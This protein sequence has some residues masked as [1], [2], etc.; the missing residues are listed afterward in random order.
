MGPLSGTTHLPSPPKNL[1]FRVHNARSIP[2]SEHVVCRIQL[3]QPLT[4]DKASVAKRTPYMTKCSAVMLADQIYRSSSLSGLAED[5]ERRRISDKEV[6][7]K[8]VIQCIIDTLH[9]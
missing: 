3:K 4:T 8:R 5:R 6:S 9:S 7:R 2:L 1:P